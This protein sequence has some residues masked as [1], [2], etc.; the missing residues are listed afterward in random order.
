MRGTRKT[1]RAKARQASKLAEI[2]KALI[3]AGCDTT[4]KQAAVLGV[5]RS[6]TWAV[7][8][9]DKRA[10]LPPMSSNAFFHRRTL[11]PAARRKVEEYVEEK[12]RGLYGHSEPRMQAFRDTFRTFNRQG[13]RLKHLPKPS[14]ACPCT[15]ASLAIFLSGPRWCKKNRLSSPQ[16]P[17]RKTQVCSNVCCRFLNGRPASP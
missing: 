4:A 10:G 12:S 11:P 16:P 5:G 7:L 3:A 17:Q 14:G 9:S 1:R 15:V 8:N 13:R 6:S 2:R